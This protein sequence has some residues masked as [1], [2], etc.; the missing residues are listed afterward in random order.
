VTFAY[1]RIEGDA[2]T[3]GRAYG[4]EAGEIIRRGLAI[5]KPALEAA[6]IGEAEFARRCRA[7]EETINGYAPELMVELKAVSEGADL[8]VNDLLLI[9]A[10]TELLYGG[11]GT[12]PADGCTAAVALPKATG[13]PLLHGQNWDWRDECVH[14]TIILHVLPN[15]GPEII[16]L[17]E[18]GGLA[19]CGLNSAGIAITGN[20]LKCERDRG[21]GGIPLALIRRKALNCAHYADAIGVIATSPVSFSNNLIVSSSHGHAVNFEKVPGDVFWLMEDGD[22][23]IVHSNHFVSEAA[24]AKVS[25]LGIAV[26]PDTLYRDAR[27]RHRLRR[28]LPHGVTEDSFKAALADR[29]QWPQSVC[30]PPIAGGVGGAVVSTVAT[31]IM[32]VSEGKFHVRKAPY[33]DG[34]YATYELETTPAAVT[35]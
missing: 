30:R 19:R 25:D 35:D 2:L 17:V 9:N 13:G 29:F 24:R 21:V 8:P 6:G 32:N 12:E 1:I 4:R 10:R 14:S 20:F 18:A 22:G 31:V 33:A 23:L 15:D 3:R 7:F 27:V 26:S 34:E 28:D 16:S 5:Y 11:K